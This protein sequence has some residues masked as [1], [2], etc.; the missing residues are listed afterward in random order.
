MKRADGAMHDN[1]GR[2]RGRGNDKMWIHFI[3][4]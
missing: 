4:F 2:L 1:D 3:L